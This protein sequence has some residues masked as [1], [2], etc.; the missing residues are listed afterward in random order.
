MSV[1]MQWFLQNYYSWRLPFCDPAEP[2]FARWQSARC[3]LRFFVLA[4]SSSLHSQF[5]FTQE[6]DR[7]PLQQADS[8]KLGL[9]LVGAEVV[10]VRL[11]CKKKMR[12]VDIRMCALDRACAPGAKV[13]TR[14]GRLMDASRRA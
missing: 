14:C 7:A 8:V 1:W 6:E 2:D 13:R 9:A 3:R 12:F 10:Q 11:I 4:V 5:V